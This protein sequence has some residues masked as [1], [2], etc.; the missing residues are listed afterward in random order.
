MRYCIRLTG[1]R[2]R[3]LSLIEAISIRCIFPIPFLVRFQYLRDVERERYL[4]L[5][6]GF[7]RDELAK[8][9]S[10]LMTIAI[11]L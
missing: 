8:A 5:M 10:S 9:I 4:R 11:K 1:Y 3:H 6:F 7:Q 2:H